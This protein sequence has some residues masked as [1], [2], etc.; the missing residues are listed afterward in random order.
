[1]AL[2]T[3]PAKDGAGIL[4]PIRVTPR[5]GHNRIEG[6]VQ[7]AD[8]TTRLKV[9]VTA[10]PADGAANRAVIA[11]LAKTWKLP[12]SRLTIAAGAGARAKTVLVAGDPRAILERVSRGGSAK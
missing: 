4:V 1:M 12:K 10:A 8:G 3:R 6:P 5:G 7:D 2:S 11:L 9:T